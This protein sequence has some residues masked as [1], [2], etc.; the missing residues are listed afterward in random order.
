MGDE[1]PFTVRDRRRSQ[2]ET[3]SSPPPRPSPPPASPPAPSSA[4]GHPDQG[5]A[6][7]RTVLQPASLS[8]LILSLGTSAFAALGAQF[9]LGTEAS[10]GAA[11]DQPPDLDH[12]R[13]LIDLLG[14]VEQKTAGNLSSDEQQLLQQLL[15][16]LRLTFVEQNRSGPPAPP[17]GAR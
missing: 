3:A 12:A 11:A 17:G 5:Q 6:D 16:T 8:E 15:Y 4:A 10:A 13:H 9:P 14:V 1:S 2:G 7:R